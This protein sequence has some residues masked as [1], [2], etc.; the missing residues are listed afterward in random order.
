MQFKE[1]LTHC[2]KH[3]HQSN[4]KKHFPFLEPYLVRGDEKC[5]YV[6]PD[7]EEKTVLMAFRL[8]GKRYEP[9]PPTL[10]VEKKNEPLVGLERPNA[11]L[12]SSFPQNQIVN[13]FGEI[14]N[15][16]Y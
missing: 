5:V 4:K 10:E 11:L 13:H 8:L 2:L 16:K 9:Q 12:I 6:Y 3:F 1:H 7:V 15:P 14:I